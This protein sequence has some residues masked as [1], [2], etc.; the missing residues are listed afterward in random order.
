[1]QPSV[2]F[3]LLPQFIIA[4]MLSLYYFYWVSDVKYP[5]L[6]EP[7]M[8]VHSPNEVSDP[9]A[10]DVEFTPLHPERFREDTVK[11]E[12][13]RALNSVSIW[14][15]ILLVASPTE[16]LIVLVG[17]FPKSIESVVFTC[18]AAIFSVSL[19]SSVVDKIGASR[20]R[21]IAAIVVAAI[22]SVLSFYFPSIAWITRIRT[23]IVILMMY[24]AALGVVGLGY[25]LQ[26][27]IKRNDLI[28]TG[29]LSS[30][31]VYGILV[32]LFAYTLMLHALYG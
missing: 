23:I 4:S 26:W 22:I 18:L 29:F 3:N 19:F 17:S 31:A 7:S 25:Y 5:V 10:D 9:S 27:K 15:I 14:I 24:L 6:V 11:I 28:K 1:M 12:M 32:S 21:K 30:V 16:T 13:T 2:A 20:N 8:L